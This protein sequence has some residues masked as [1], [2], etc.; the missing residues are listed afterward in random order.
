MPPEKDTDASAFLLV[1]TGVISLAAAALTVP[2]VVYVT[3]AIVSS[4]D[5]TSNKSKSSCSACLFLAGETLSKRSGTSSVFFT[6][7]RFRKAVIPL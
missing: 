3:T 2:W 1:V 7:E 4:F 5:Y 6:R